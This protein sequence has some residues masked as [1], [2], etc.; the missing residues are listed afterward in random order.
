MEKHSGVT[1][2]PPP[3]QVNIIILMRLKFQFNKNLEAHRHTNDGIAI[4]TTLKD[5]YLFCL[6]E[7]D[8]S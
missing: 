7:F 8:S 1:A 2:P 4:P 3:P 5:K 6:S